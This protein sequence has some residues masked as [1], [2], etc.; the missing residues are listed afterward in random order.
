VLAI[1]RLSRATL[2]ASAVLSLALLPELAWGQNPG[3]RPQVPPNHQVGP[4][5]GDLG[6]A[7][8]QVP[9]G[10]VFVPRHAMA[11]FC[12]MTGNP[13]HGAEVGAMYPE[14]FSYVIF[15]QYEGEADGHVKDDDKNSL[16]DAGGLLQSIK[17]GTEEENRWRRDN[18]QSEYHV[19]G[20]EKPP[21]YDENTHNLTWALRG[22]SD[23]QHNIN[24]NSRLLGRVGYTS[25]N[26]VCSPNDLNKTVGIYNNLLK[27]FAYKPGNTYAEFNPSTD[28]VAAGGL[29]ALLGI[30]AVAAAA[31]A[32]WLT[33]F[34]KFIIVGIVAFFGAIGAFFR[35]LFGGKTST[36]S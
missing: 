13:P 8:I 9:A 7:T 29:A 22:E 18:K 24:Y 36:S 21:F 14:D 15:F 30:G 17:D 10:Y 34:G 19:I 16:P 11:E 33:K 6:K 2:W 5:V 28:K 20:W 12:R 25:A 31:K 4:L 1:S 32:G 35:R 27:S 26:L 23:G 3:Q